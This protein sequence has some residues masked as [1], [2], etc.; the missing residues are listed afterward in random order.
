MLEKEQIML[1]AEE[2]VQLERDI[3]TAGGDGD[4]I[5]GVMLRYMRRE[6]N[7][8]DEQLQPFISG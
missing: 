4:V 3:E 6:E 1:D 8:C 5:S 2:H 7:K